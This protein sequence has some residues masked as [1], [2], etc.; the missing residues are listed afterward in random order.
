[1][2]DDI[3]KEISPRDIMRSVGRGFDRLENFRLARL[4]FIKQY[5]GSYYDKVQGEVGANVLNLIFNAIRVLTPTM[6]FNFP[7]HNIETP[8]LQTRQYATLLGLALDQHSQK[9]NICDTYRRCIVDALFTLGIIKTGLAQS[10]SV[11]AMTGEDGIDPGTIYSEAVDFD[12]FV[13]DPDSKEHMFKDA[14]FMGDRQRVP[15][16]ILLDLPGIDTDLVM[17][18]PRV[19]DTNARERSENISKRNIEPQDN[20]DLEDDVEIVEVWVPGANVVLTIPGGDKT[21]FDDYLRV[22]DYYGVKEGPYSLL[23]LTPPV[24]ANPLPVPMVGIWQ[25]LHIRA[26]QMA[27]KIIEQA[28]RQK[29]LVA[30]QGAA[31]DDAQALLDAGDGEAIKVDDVQA[32][33]TL[34]FGGQQNSN[35]IHLESLTSWFNMMAAN[36]DQV[37]GQRIDAK[38]ATGVQALQQNAAIGLED[39]KDMVYKFAASEARKRAWFMHTDPLMQIPLIQRQQTQTPMQIGG[40]LMMMPT[41]QDVQVILTPE[42][43]SGD[44]LDYTFQIEP[45]SMSR[46]D[47]KLRLQQMMTFLQ[48]IMPAI[49]TSAQVAAGIGIPFNAVP[50]M[51]RA[52]KE[53]GIMW[54]D[55][56]LYDP[57][58]QQQM[59]Q[60]M[61]MGPQNQGKGQAQPNSNLGAQLQNGQPGN[62]QGAPPTPATQQNQQ[63]QQGANDAQKFLFRETMRKAF[64]SQTPQNALPNAQGL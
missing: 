26:N 57:Q 32:I 37:G 31:A 60:Q 55:E 17:R 35:E 21:E 6:V 27:K 61:M 42:Q 56:V 39:M 44:W 12:N 48:Q 10:D 29:S 7:K 41:M 36:P 1:M 54:L 24:P 46:V 49:M 59:M 40:M 14:K 13:V 4:H 58:F 15:R 33:T 5:V 30:Y 18:L 19:D 2:A 38:T 28:D 25:D 63:A 64:P 8:Y 9:I 43:R 3:T 22:T 45:E 51:I 23:C 34:N 50:L 62:V 11:L 20:Y 52:A 47:S 53:M 16:Q